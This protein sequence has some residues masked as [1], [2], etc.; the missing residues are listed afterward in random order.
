M[1]RSAVEAPMSSSYE[2]SRYLARTLAATLLDLGPRQRSEV[3][4]YLEDEL[5][6]LSIPMTLGG[7]PIP[8]T[9]EE[10]RDRN[11]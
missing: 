7:A 10:P 1:E 4:A 3:L 5:E 11:G 8:A 2:D 6:R 9:A